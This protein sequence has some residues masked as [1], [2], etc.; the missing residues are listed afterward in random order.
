MREEIGREKR[1]KKDVEKMRSGGSWG[2]SG[3]KRRI[4]RDKLMVRCRGQW[5]EL[6]KVVSC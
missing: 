5:W 1:M 4:S 6:K 3:S 2:E